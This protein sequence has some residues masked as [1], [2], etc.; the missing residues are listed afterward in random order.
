MNKN[1]NEIGDKRESHFYHNILI[2][3]YENVIWCKNYQKLIDRKLKIDFIGIKKSN[4][5]NDY[6]IDFIQIGSIKKV[7]SDNLFYIRNILTKK[8]ELSNFLYVFLIN[9]GF[10]EDKKKY[11]FY[12]R[13]YIITEKF[14]YKDYKAYIKKVSF[15][16]N[17]KKQLK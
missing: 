4:W 8:N 3:E 16:I 12:Y 5:T 13:F 17:K 15:I 10:I 9:K 14:L 7:W 11:I 2:N 6:E 1:N